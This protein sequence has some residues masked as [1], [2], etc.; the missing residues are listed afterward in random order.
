MLSVVPMLDI[1][2][3][4]DVIYLDFSKA[5]NRVCHDILI[6]K[7]I[8][9]FRFHDN[10][11]GLIRSY[12]VGRGNFVEILGFR[13]F[14]HLASSGVPQGSNLGPLLFVLFIDDI[15]EVLSS[16]SLLYAVTCG[17]TRL[18]NA[19]YGNNLKALA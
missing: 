3:Q 16:R 11:V 4:A 14:T 5:F 17:D 9:R 8:H 19:Y 15:S 1:Y 7:L 18:I 10:L 13:S 6:Y 12:L 2:H